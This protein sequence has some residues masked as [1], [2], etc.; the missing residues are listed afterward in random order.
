MSQHVRSRHL[1]AV[2]VSLTALSS[3]VPAQEARRTA[4][5]P[6]EQIQIPPASMEWNDLI[7][8]QASLPQW[9]VT[10]WQTESVI[11]EPPQF[12]LGENARLAQPG[13]PASGQQ[14]MTTC[15]GFP[16]EP[17]MSQDFAGQADV[18]DT[19]GFVFI[20]PDT[21]GGVGPAHLMT[22]LNNK[23]L[24]QDRLGSSVSSVDLFVFWT[25]L[26]VTTPTY[27]RV[28]YDATSGRWIVTGWDGPRATS[29]V[30]FAISDT[31]DPTGSWDFYS[32]VADGT[33]I[34]FA[35][36]VTT[37]YNGTW[38]AIASN[39]FN[40][41]PPN[42]FVG[43]K[44]W[45][46]EK[47][48]ALAGGP[49]T[50]TIF[51]TGFHTAATGGFGGASL[52]PATT[53]D[54]AEP[55]LYLLNQSFTS[56]IMGVVTPLIT[57]TE[58]SG[59]GPAPVVAGVPGSTFGGPASGL[60]P[61]T[62]VYSAS[63][64]RT[65]S[66]LGDPRTI[67]P[68]STRI[69]QVLV[70]NSRIWAVNAGG[71][72]VPGTINRTV[73]CWYQID[74]AAMPTPIVQSGQ[75]DGGSG[76]CQWVPSIAVN[77][78]D[79]AVVG[80]SRGDASKFAES[81]Y[82]MR[83]G[84]DALST[85]GPMRVLKTGE[86]FYFKTFGGPT[87]LW[88]RYS[89][90]NVDPVDDKTFWSIQEYAALRVGPADNDSRWGTW[91]GRIGS[92]GQP[93]I[94]D[95]PDPVG[96][97]CETGTATFSVSATASNAPLGFQWRRNGVPLVGETGSTLVISPVQPSD[98]GSYDVV[99]EDG[100]GEVVSIARTLK[101]KKLPEFIT[102]PLSQEVE[103]HVTVTLT[104]RVKR[105]TSSLADPDI[106]I[107][108]WRKDNVPIPGATDRTFTLFDVDVDDEGTYDV[109]AT[110]NCGSTTSNPAVLEVIHGPR[111]KKTSETADDTVEETTD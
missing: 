89:A 97:V 8:L 61:V 99:V 20:P 92:C 43:P 79:D 51:P 68:F 22:A 80:F 16:L 9:P 87:N 66:Q 38:I 36:W 105:Q 91:W 15:A 46:I 54:P 71:L 21:M 83:L 62:N 53:Y 24:I 18:P 1:F 3:L 106:T 49:L 12:G 64:L 102:H 45:V 5:R 110:N 88:G 74:A 48:T 84:T 98:G 57:A 13:A 93:T 86:S 104:S 39:M 58:I 81:A 60:F 101:V 76:T 2:V 4:A 40:V 19:N 67:S 109:V 56:T 111:A 17:S 85:M 103:R 23:V 69:A 27:T 75:I 55:K 72:P 52:F 41:A 14:E 34:T 29:R 30:L 95:Q 73:V 50:V 11:I 63:T 31:D 78:A 25:A 44:M 65:C 42:A 94:T 35:D 33:S 96:T 26:A 32:F 47:A 6:T 90:T 70:R 10:N 59:T 107:F 100:C 37:G 77:C 28:L 82:A 108:Q 7:Q